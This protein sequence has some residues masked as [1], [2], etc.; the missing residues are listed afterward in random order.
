MGAGMR[1]GV[2]AFAPASI[3]R[4]GGPNATAETAMRRFSGENATAGTHL[5][6]NRDYVKCFHVKRAQKHMPPRLPVARYGAIAGRHK[7]LCPSLRRG[8]TARYH[9]TPT[10]LTARSVLCHARTRVRIAASVRDFA[11]HT[12]SSASLHSPSITSSFACTLAS[13]AAACACRSVTLMF[14]AT[15]L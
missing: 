1:V 2:I 15:S 7:I 11:S 13:N 9:D 12:S 10:L 3:C 14:T 8:V 6:D 5:A 4:R